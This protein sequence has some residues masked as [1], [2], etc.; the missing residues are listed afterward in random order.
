MKRLAVLLFVFSMVFAIKQVEI[1]ISTNATVV[2]MN[3][4]GFLTVATNQAI[5]VNWEGT[6]VSATSFPIAAN[7]SATTKGLVFETQTI[8]VKSD[9]GTANMVLIFE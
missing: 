4:K 9:S 3:Y 7:G 6:T 1:P 5:H 2:T 8:Q